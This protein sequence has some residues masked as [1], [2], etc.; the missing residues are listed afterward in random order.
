MTYNEWERELLRYLKGLPKKERDEV[1]DYYREMH[2]D[3]FDAGMTDEQIIK[4]FGEPKLVTSSPLI[5]SPP[6]CG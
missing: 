6:P 5:P 1:A 3:K 4:K 2:G